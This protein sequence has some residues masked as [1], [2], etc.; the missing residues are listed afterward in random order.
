MG[1][2][3]TISN[4]GIKDTD[5]SDVTRRYKVVNRYCFL[6][7]ITTFFFALL[8]YILGHH[9]YFCV[10]VI[11]GPFTSLYV[12]FSFRRQYTG[13]FYWMFCTILINVFYASLEVKGSGVEYYLIPLGFGTFLA[14]ENKKSCV[15]LMTLCAIAFFIAFFLRESYQS[16]FTIPHPAID[17]M[18]V[19]ILTS[20]FILCAVFVYQFTMVNDLHERIIQIQ[21][22][23]TA[24]NNKNISQHLH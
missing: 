2:W 10:Q 17:F 20:N 7:A 3:Q 1:F 4:I 12:V 6:A 11:A 19:M 24:E 15:A 18:F 5:T 22:L 13:A 14:I 8:L 9:Y 23:D 21:K 16:A